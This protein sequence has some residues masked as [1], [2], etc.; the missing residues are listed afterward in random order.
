ML[1]SSTTF[2]V[3]PMLI[4]ITILCSSMLLSQAGTYCNAHQYYSGGRCEECDATCDECRYYV[5]GSCSNCTDGYR[6]S[7]SSSCSFTCPYTNQFLNFNYQVC[8]SCASW[9]TRGCIEARDNCNPCYSGQYYRPD[10]GT[11]N[12]TCPQY[13][14]FYASSTE[15]RCI[16]CRDP[17]CLR[18]K[19]NGDCDECKSFWHLNGT[20]GRCSRKCPIGCKFCTESGVCTQC[21]TGWNMTSSSTCSCP[22][23]YCRECNSTGCA[24]CQEGYVKDVSGACKSTVPNCRQYNSTT[25]CEI[26]EAGFYLWNNNC[27]QC[28]TGCRHCISNPN[29]C[30][31]CENGYY[32]NTTYYTLYPTCLLK[33]S[34]SPT[35]TPT[36]GP[37]PDPYNPSSPSNSGWIIALLFG[38]VIIILIIAG[39]M[40][41]QAKKKRQAAAA[42]QDESGAS[43]V[44]YAQISNNATSAYLAFQQPGGYST[45]QIYYPADQKDRDSNYYFPSN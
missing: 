23:S 40:I 43:A 19:S 18:C 7:S 14:G 1:S 17:N 37:T 45:Q 26:C 33:T 30:T 2:K 15:N 10:L 29:N 3:L 34:K 36:P 5:P 35:P 8:E 21:E 28:K 32:L 31:A 39:V 16:P 27:Y 6:N 24:R 38:G 44:A 25:T 42:Q 9:C 11:C 12:S 4:W 13:G 41:A 20:T 22:Y